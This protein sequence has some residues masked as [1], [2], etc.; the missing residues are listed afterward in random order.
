MSYLYD[1]QSGQSSGGGGGFLTSTRDIS[2]D[3]LQNL[4]LQ[5]IIL[6]PAPGV[7]KRLSVLSFDIE[8]TPGVAAR[9]SDSRV[10]QIA[11]IPSEVD[12][13]RLD[14]YSD[15]YN[16]CI[17]RRRS[18]HYIPAGAYFQHEDV[19]SHGVVENTPICFAI[20]SSLRLSP[21]RSV[22]GTPTGGLNFSVNYV[23]V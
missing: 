16:Y 8:R 1:N 13:G 6:V 14:F 7:G 3:E 4:I 10:G 21:D 11:L 2:T 23:I 20:V 15:E 9:V 12:A 18:D 17:W 5:R 22:Y 19:V